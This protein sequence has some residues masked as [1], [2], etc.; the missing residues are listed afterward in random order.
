[1]KNTENYLNKK[2][3]RPYVA[4]IRTTS[5]YFSS[6]KS[7][8]LDWLQLIPAILGALVGIGVGC[9]VL[10]LFFLCITKLV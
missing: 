4:C 1:M 3:S 8:L 7:Y 6:C 10:Y 2:G 9:F 5:A